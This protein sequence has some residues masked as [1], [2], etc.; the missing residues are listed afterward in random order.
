MD[1]DMATEMP[2]KVELLTFQSA[3]ALR[4]EKIAS[5]LNLLGVFSKYGT[6]LQNTTTTSL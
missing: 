5:V 1:M 2:K 6:T 4:N 3:N